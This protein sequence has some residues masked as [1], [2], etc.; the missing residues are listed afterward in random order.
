LIVNLEF[1]KIFLFLV[2]HITQ[3]AIKQVSR[4]N[5]R[6]KALLTRIILW[7]IRMDKS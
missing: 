6:E 7:L 2:F 3:I 4:K 1:S 5:L